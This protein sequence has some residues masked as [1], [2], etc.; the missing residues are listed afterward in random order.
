E[1]A[2]PEK[3]VILRTD[4]RALS[5]I[6][7]NL[8]NNGIKYTDKGSVHIEL[9]QYKPNG[10]FVTEFR[11][12]DTGIGIRSEDQ[13]KLF[14]AFQQ[15]DSSRRGEGTGLG[16]HLSRKLAE[17]LG[18]QIDFESTYGSG[19]RFSLIFHGR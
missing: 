4:R 19:S 2:T 14:Q 13:V 15:V 8:A 6:L 12:I 7:I 18:A 9:S 16:L 11:V 1:I 17:L 5:Q 3:P 10:H